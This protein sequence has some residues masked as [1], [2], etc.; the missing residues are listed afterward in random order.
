M[1]RDEPP[2]PQIIKTEKGLRPFRAWDGEDL[3]ADP[4]GTVYEVVKT[5][6][7]RPR[8]N[9]TYWKALS[10]AV[11][12]TDRWA[13]ARHLHE[14]L[15][16]ACGYY[17]KA[18]SLKTGEEILLPDSTAFSK[19]DQTEW[20]TY[21]DKAMFVLSNAIGYDALSFISEND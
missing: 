7:R 6:K 5:N 11:K 4:M 18:V 3:A 12:S 9:N 10:L 15:K 2:S 8:Q 1:K 16:L 13:T 21:M 17:R 14:E 19:M 20:Q